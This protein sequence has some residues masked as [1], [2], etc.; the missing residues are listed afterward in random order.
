MPCNATDTAKCP[1]PSGPKSSTAK[2]P[3]HTTDHPM[4]HNHTVDLLQTTH[5][6][7]KSGK[8]PPYPHR[9]ASRTHHPTLRHTMTPYVTA[10]L[11]RWLTFKPLCFAH[12]GPQTTI[13]HQK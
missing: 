11:K 13:Q 10:L 7:A 9:H 3:N 2:T 1:P 4:H 8:S 5:Q 6:K 12:K